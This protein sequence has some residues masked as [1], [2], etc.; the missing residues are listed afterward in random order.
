VEISL[1]FRAHPSEDLL[2][3]YSFGRLNEFQAAPLEEHLLVCTSCQQTLAGLDQYIL[4]VKMAAGPEVLSL[5]PPRWRIWFDRLNEWAGGGRRR[6]VRVVWTTALA[7]AMGSAA[8]LLLLR[9]QASISP[10]VA[11]ELVS[12]RGGG[13]AAS[14]VATAGRPLDL[15]VDIPDLPSAASYR[16]EVVTTTGSRV[17]EGAPH[18]AGGKLSAHLPQ[19]LRPGA[20]WVRLYA[21]PA[22][23]LSEYGLR[24][25]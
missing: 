6:A 18:T 12:Y 13:N 19:G 8:A 24:I 3:E 4:L 22:D 2:E 7:G 9:S 1:V 25:Q 10:P 5:T 21:T 11:I 20:Y 23:L 17:W 15:A 16:V 14:A